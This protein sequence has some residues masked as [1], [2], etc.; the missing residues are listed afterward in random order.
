MIVLLA[1]CAIIDWRMSS[2][3]W[4]SKELKPLFSPSGKT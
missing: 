2:N 4:E 1:E 3:Y